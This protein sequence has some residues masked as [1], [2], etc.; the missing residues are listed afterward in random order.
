MMFTKPISALDFDDITDFCKERNPETFILDYKK[1]FPTH[2]DRTICAFANTWGGIILVGVDEDEERKPKLPIDGVMYRSTLGETVTNV[3]VDNIYPPVFVDKNV[4]KFNQ[5]KAVIVIQVPQSNVFHASDKG[6]RI[7]VRTDDRNKPEQLATIE[8][9]EWLWDRRRKSEEFRQTLY[10]S[11][12]ERLEKIYSLPQLWA[13]R[14]L[15]P[16]EAQVETSRIP[17]P[18]RATFSVTPVFPD[19]AFTSTNELKKICSSL[20]VRSPYTH[21]YGDDFPELVNR[22]R[23]TQ[24]SVI[25]YC[26][27][28]PRE[29]FW[30]YEFSKYGLFLYQEPLLWKVSTGDYIECVH[31]IARLDL[32]LEAAKT[33]F[34]KLNVSGLIEFKLTVNDIFGRRIIWDISNPFDNRFGPSHDIAFEAKRT[35][36]KEE[37]MSSR[38][39]II[40]E[41]IQEIQFAFN[42]NIPEESVKEYLKRHERLSLKS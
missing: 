4:I 23:T 16:D 14:K 2:L 29:G 31:I 34:D 32:F 22:V 3:I 12:I 27:T 35:F 37:L 9:L 17:S 36:Y 24:E 42:F 39:V 11:V 33:F 18:G 13:H 7:Y 26:E 19:R 40:K 6:R 30:F 20:R 38:L 28:L 10:A 5:N 8:R 1:D 15:E 21:R 41:I 25:N